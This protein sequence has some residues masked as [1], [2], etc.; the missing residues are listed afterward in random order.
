MKQALSTLLLFFVSFYFSQTQ[1]KVINADNKK[2]VPDASVYC[3]D[4]L[5]GKTSQNGILTFKTKCKKVDILANDFEDEEAAVSKEMLVSLKPTSE[6][7]KSIN[8][9]TIADKSDPRALKILDELLKRYK[10]N[11]PQSLDSYNFKSY[12]KISFYYCFLFSLKHNF[13]HLHR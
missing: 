11:S 6:K 9:V 10:E 3:D 13:Q 2:P 7:T 4:N 1:L 5:L 12:S 8:R